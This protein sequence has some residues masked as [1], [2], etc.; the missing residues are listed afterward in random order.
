VLGNGY[1]DEYGHLNL[2]YVE[3]RHLNMNNVKESLRSRCWDSQLHQL[4]PVTLV[5]FMRAMVGEGPQ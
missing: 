4:S 2:N 3:H 5:D 1:D